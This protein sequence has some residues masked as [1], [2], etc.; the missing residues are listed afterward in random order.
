M[1]VVSPP[2]SMTMLPAASVI[3]SPSRSAAIGSSTRCTSLALARNA[4]SL[5]ARRSTGV[6]SGGTPITR[7]GRSSGRFPA[8]LRMKWVS[9]FSAASKSAMTPSR[10]GRT[11]VMLAGVRPSISCASIP[12]ASMFPFTVLNATIDGS[13]RTM[14]RPRAK[15]Q[16]LAVPR[17]MA[18]SVAKA[19]RKLIVNS[20][21][22]TAEPPCGDPAAP[23]EDSDCSRASTA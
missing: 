1:S 18:T 5:T 10:I 4:L 3:G 6:I 16:V 19:D 14:P 13:F 23:V 21:K 15:M 12:T 9:I 2:M 7:R 17:S 11:G 22:L 20:G 8:T